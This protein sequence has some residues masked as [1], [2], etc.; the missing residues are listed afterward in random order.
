MKPLSKHRPYF[1][2]AG[3]AFCLLAPALHAQAAKAPAATARSTEAAEHLRSRL[4]IYDLHDG[5]SHLVYTADSIWE[6][7]NWS[8]DGTYLLSNSGG[9]IYRFTLAK[10]GTAEPKELAI[11][12]KFDCNN[13]KA[14]SPDG[15]KLAFSATATGSDGSQVFLADADGGNIKL[16]VSETPSYLPW[17]VAG[18][19]D[20]CLCGPAERKK[21]IRYL[22]SARRRRDGATAH[23]QHS[24]R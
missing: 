10:D 22:S 17:L 13:D 16:M 23:L 24:P 8:P 7:P 1:G 15:K 6:A 2:L 18:Q 20:A 19:Q 21:S 3:I 12:S 9:H 5:S 4:F 14:I 11:P